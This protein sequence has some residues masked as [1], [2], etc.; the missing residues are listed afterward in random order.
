MAIPEPEVIGGARYSIGT[1]SW[2][3]GTETF[4]L[5][6]AD[7]A[8]DEAIEE[9]EATIDTTGLT[10]GRYTVFV[11]S[12]DAEGNYGVP[13]AVFLDVLEAPAA[14][15]TVFDGN[16]EVDRSVGGSG[17]DVLYGRGGDDVLAGGQGDDLLIGGDGDDLLRGDH[18]TSSSGGRQGGDDVIYGGRG[19]DR[20]SGKG[21]D[22]KLYGD[23]GDDVL[24]GDAGDDLLWG[25][26][27]RDRLDGGRGS[28]I[29]A[30]GVGGGTD[31]IRGF[32]VGTDSIGLVGTLS[33]GQL[34]ITQDRNN[35]AIGYGDN[36]F[37]VLHQVSASALS[38][39]AFVPV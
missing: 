10:V 28:D 18:N 30:I 26:A 15:A 13:T 7:G 14:N 2:A 9:L 33:F 4:E 6:A 24:Y 3:E 21:G 27:G 12:A 22:D 19:S 37:A 31:S 36:I 25:G 39:S 5:S 8:F 11:E 34:S 23:A 1:P 35:T 16:A 32:E 17:S 20:I 29:F 38:E